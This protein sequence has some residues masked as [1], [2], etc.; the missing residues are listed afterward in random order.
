MCKNW[1]QIIIGE[2][3]LKILC[4]KYGINSDKI[5]N[6]NNNILTYGEYQDIDS[7]LNYLVKI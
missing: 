5:V 4:E 6:K 3:T 7:T 2:Y 1:R